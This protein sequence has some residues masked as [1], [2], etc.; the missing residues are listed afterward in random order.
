MVVCAVDREFHKLQGQ[1]PVRKKKKKKETHHQAQ[2]ATCPKEDTVFVK[3]KYRVR[4]EVR[5]WSRKNL[6]S[7][8]GHSSLCGSI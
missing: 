6:W 1:E 3:P 5:D 2:V 4:L 8:S 7:G